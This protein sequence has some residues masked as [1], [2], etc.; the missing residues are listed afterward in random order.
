MAHGFLLRKGRDSN[1]WYGYPYDSLANCWFQPLTHPSPRRSVLGHVM[2]EMLF[3]ESGCKGTTKNANTQIFLEKNVF[4]YKKSAHGLHFT[5][6]FVYHS[7]TTLTFLLCFFILVFVHARTRIR[8]EVLHY[9]TIR[10]RKISPSIPCRCGLCISPHLPLRVVN[11]STPMLSP[12]SQKK[13][14]AQSRRN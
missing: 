14:L 2:S 6:F 8:K 9:Y 12:P 13:I 3:F 10:A 7:V 5:R 11:F 4:L 1:S